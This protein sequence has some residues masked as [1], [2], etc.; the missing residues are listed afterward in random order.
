MVEVYYTEQQ[1]TRT[2]QVELMKELRGGAKVAV[3]D[4]KK[5]M[6]TAIDSG[7]DKACCYSDAKM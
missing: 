4:A 7:F 5:A 6:S 3:G 2:K 1:D